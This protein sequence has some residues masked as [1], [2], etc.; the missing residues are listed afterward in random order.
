VENHRLIEGSAAP[1]LESPP[2]SVTPTHFKPSNHE[3]GSVK[4]N[5]ARKLSRISLALIFLAGELVYVNSAF[6]EALPPKT[7]DVPFVP[8]ST[9]RKILEHMQEANL[10][11]LKG[12]PGMIFYCPTDEAK[13]P[14]L[15]QICV[16]SYPNLEALAIQQGVK[17]HKA[18]NANDVALL[19]HLTG[20]L[21]LVIELTGTESGATPAAIAARVVVLAHYTGAINRASELSS[22]G[23]AVDS[24]QAKHP[25][26]LPQHVDAIL[27][28]ASLIKAA[29]SG[30]EEL[31]RPMVDAINEKLKA[32]FADYAKA[33]R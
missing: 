32:F 16:E 4:T 27:W 2:E 22:S 17:F 8:D 7:Q 31:V 25:L 14:A 18:R 5:L 24:G 6:A 1:D 11:R 12:W 21:K 30:Q 3:G 19:P 10:T 26:S 9:E 28:E 13:T 15:R 33:N 20:R 23:S 29:S